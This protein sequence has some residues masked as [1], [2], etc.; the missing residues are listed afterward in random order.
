MHLITGTMVANSKY[1]IESQ[2]KVIEIKEHQ[3]LK[4]TNK[5]SEVALD[6][7]ENTIH[8]YKLLKYDAYNMKVPNWKAIPMWV[9]PKM[10]INVLHNIL[11]SW[12]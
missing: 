3:L 2:K 1:V 11:R 6:R 10:E 5:A 4:T 9:Y 12:V 7:Q 8:S